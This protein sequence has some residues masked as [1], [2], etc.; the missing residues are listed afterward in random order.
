MNHAPPVGVVEGVEN[1]DDDVD[2]RFEGRQTG[3]S[4]QRSQTRSLEVLHHDVDAPFHLEHVVNGDD[5][6]M[7]QP[8]TGARFAQEP[9]DGLKARVSRPERLDRDG[10]LEHRV[11][12]LVDVTHAAASEPRLDAEAIDEAA[13]RIVRG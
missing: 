10:A 1:P 9:F 3:K 8:R 4:M 2:L 6:G 7:R 13:G 12:R 5:A 11:I